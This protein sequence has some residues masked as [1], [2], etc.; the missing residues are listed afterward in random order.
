MVLLAFQLQWLSAQKAVGKNPR[1]LLLDKSVLSGV[2]LKKIDFK[3]EPE[4]QFYQKRLYLFKRFRS[5]SQR[6]YWKMEMR[7]NKTQ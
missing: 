5:P 1:P 2:G 7:R 6:L 4:K 3:E